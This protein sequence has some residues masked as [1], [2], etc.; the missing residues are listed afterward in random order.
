MAKS[1]AR[2]RWLLT[3][4]QLLRTGGIRSVK[5][6]ALCE[7]AGLTTGSFYHHFQNIAAYRNELATFYG[8]DQVHQLI[9]SITVVDPYD[10]LTAVVALA[11]D[12]SMG[13]LDVAMRDWASTDAKAAA[14]VEAADT[15]LLEHFARLFED[16]GHTQDEAR[17][18]AL[19][20]LSAGVSRV[21]NPWRVP[22]VTA[23]LLRLLAGQC[24][25][26]S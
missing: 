14:A 6:D 11:Q 18:R 12:K 21:H 19:L 20:L 2:V 1:T 13:P 5:L 7:A 9:S 23:T 10:Q 16:L 17:L 24:Y 15:A 8:S 26:P 4:Q 3:G 25:E 22:N